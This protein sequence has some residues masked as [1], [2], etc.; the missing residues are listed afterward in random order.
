MTKK[1]K[2][3]EFIEHNDE[4][5]FTIFRR[6]NKYFRVGWKGS[7]FPGEVE[8]CFHLGW[9]WLT[10]EELSAERRLSPTCRP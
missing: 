1:A 4:G 5:K 6:D 10:Q 8:V 3:T 2:G 9:G 7:E